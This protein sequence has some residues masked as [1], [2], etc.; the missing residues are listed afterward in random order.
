MAA[1]STVSVQ[2]LAAERNR[3][4]SRARCCRGNFSL[5]DAFAEMEKLIIKFIWKVWVPGSGEAGF[6][7]DLFSGNAAFYQ[8][9]L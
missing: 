9:V 6:Y 7:C 8:E 1:A 3:G 2:L 5:P 4:V